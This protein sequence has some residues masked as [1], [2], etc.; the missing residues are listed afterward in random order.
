VRAGLEVGAAR[1]LETMRST[2]YSGDAK[3]VPS[4][5]LGAVDVAPLEVAQMYGTLAAG[6]YQ[7]PLSA[8]REVTTKEGTPLNRYPIKVRQVLP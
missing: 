2:G 3:A 1:V 8:I 6:G 5:F 4:V 7:T